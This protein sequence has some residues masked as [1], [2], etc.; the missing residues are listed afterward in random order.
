MKKSIL[1]AIIA[2]LFLPSCDNYQPISH[3]E[4]LKNHTYSIGQQRLELTDESRN[5]PIKTEIWYPTT[6]T[7]GFN[8]SV[9]YPFKLPP[10]SQDAELPDGEFPL[11]LMSHGTGSN[12]ISLM[13]LASELAA[14]GYIVAASDHYGNTLDNKIP[15]NFVKVW[16]RPRDISFVID[17]LINEPGW[18][19]H[20]DSTK[21][22][23]IGFSLG[24]YT[25]IALAG[26]EMDYQVLKEFSVSEKGKVEFN[27]PELGDI[28]QY[29][30]PKLIA[31]GEKQSQ[32][33]KDS[34]IKSFIALAPA[35]GQGYVSEKQ[36]ENVD[37]PLLIIGAANDTRTPVEENAKHY[38][39]LISKSDYFE[40]EGKVGHYVF[41]NEAKA[42]LKRSAP[43]IFTDDDSVNRNKIHAQVS[44]LVLDYFEEKM[45]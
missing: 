6:D 27:V 8:I 10:T 39:N 35:L 41:L 12:R 32:N 7:T 17:Y 33:L 25:S 31:E 34:R 37:A 30:T 23:M 1:P 45:R 18:N 15:E 26:G 38:H 42:G 29:L 9:E 24:G 5:R 14:E 36:F 40:L 16:D 3:Q 44:A 20:I 4:F 28:S 2:F 19:K 11:I 21:I 13:W 22:G 43:M